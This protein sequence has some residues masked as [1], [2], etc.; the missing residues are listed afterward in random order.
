MLF[1]PVVGSEVYDIFC[2]FDKI[3]RKMYRIFGI[4]I[5]DI[6]FFDY[7]MSHLSTKE[8]LQNAKKILSLYSRKLEKQ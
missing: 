6:I 5:S 1:P 8:L 3:I 4:E 7:F 2:Y